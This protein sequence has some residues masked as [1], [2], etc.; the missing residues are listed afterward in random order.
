MFSII[1]SSRKTFLVLTHFIN[2]YFPLNNFSHSASDIYPGKILLVLLRVFST[3]IVPGKAILSPHMQYLL[4]IVFMN[5]I[6][7][8][9]HDQCT[10]LSQVIV[11][12]NA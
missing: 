3:L 5:I 6:P 11:A 12:I 10:N 2:R 1:Y 8:F 9:P 4:T 7:A